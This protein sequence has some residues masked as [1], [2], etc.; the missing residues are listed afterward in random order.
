MNHY[1]LTFSHWSLGLA[2]FSCPFSQCGHGL[3]F[4]HW[5]LGLAMV[6]CP[7]S[8][9]GHRLYF[10]NSGAQ[11]SSFPKVAVLKLSVL[12]HC[13]FLKTVDERAFVW[14]GYIYRYLIYQKLTARTSLAVQW[15]RL[16]TSTARGHGFDP[17]LGN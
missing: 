16:R 6:S 10:Q 11:G 1:V 5:S 9:C 13:T 12:G 17:W 8:Q 14:M 2:M 4:S 7:F 15:L 3:T